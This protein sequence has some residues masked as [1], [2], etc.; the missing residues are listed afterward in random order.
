MDGEDVSR[1]VATAFFEHANLD[2]GARELSSPGRLLWR[3]H[4]AKLLHGISHRRDVKAFFNH[5]RTTVR[6]LFQ[7]S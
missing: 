7:Q 4:Q 1:L 2:L 5:G 3:C 6:Q